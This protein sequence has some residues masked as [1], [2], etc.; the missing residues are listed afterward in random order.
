M[1]TTTIETGQPTRRSRADR[2][3]RQIHREETEREPEVSIESGF[4]EPDD[5]L[6]ESQRII[7][8]RETE[9]DQARRQA[10][11]AENARRAAEQQAQQAQAGRVDDR[12]AAVAERLESGKNALSAAKL[13]YAS[14]REAGSV[15]DE[16]AAQQAM[17]EAIFS[18]NEAQRELQWIQAQPRQQAQQQAAG[19]SPAARQWIA[20]HPLY[21]EPDT[22]EDA[23]TYRAQ[24][25]YFHGAAIRSGHQDGSDAY[26]RYIDQALT[27]KFGDGHGQV[28]GQRMS[29]EREDGGYQPRGGDGMRPSGAGA[30]SGGG[31]GWKTARIPLGHNGTMAI[32]KY[33]GPPEARRIQFANERDFENFRE[34]AEVT[35]GAEFAQNEKHAIGLYVN[36]HIDAADGGY[37]DLK[38]GDGQA[39]GSDR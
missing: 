23:E 7:K 28:G 32:V 20:D 30:G 37:E 27:R 35:Y 38:R 9:R 10:Q 19:M 13:A 24:A 26:I 14:A 1:S 17:S 12:A 21:T 16:L 25:Q 36:A 11:D 33:Q 2:P 8:Q 31:G 39:W 29:R 6:A 34:G 22:N 3:D 15:P 4:Q 18:V 5:A